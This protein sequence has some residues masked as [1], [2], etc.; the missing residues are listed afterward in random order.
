VEVFCKCI[1]FLGLSFSS[2]AV[3]NYLTEN[4]KKIKSVKVYS[5]FDL[6]EVLVDL[7]TYDTLCNSGY[8]FSGSDPGAKSLLALLLSA[9]ATN[10]P[11]TVVGDTA[12]T[13]P[14]SGGSTRCHL[15]WLE[16]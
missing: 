11:V 1:V 16:F 15:Y 12:D 14:G 5:N 9:K 6:G 8:W 13:W 4:N 7:D 2:V 10:T 3:P